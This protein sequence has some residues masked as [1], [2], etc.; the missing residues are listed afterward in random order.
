MRDALLLSGRVE[1]Y[2]ESEKSPRTLRSGAFIARNL[3]WNRRVTPPTVI[4]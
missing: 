4:G 1:K 2:L 3:L